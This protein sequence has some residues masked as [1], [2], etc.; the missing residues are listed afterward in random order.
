MKSWN[1]GWINGIMEKWNNGIKYLCTDGLNILDL[2][3][4]AKKVEKDCRLNRKPIFLHM[5]IPMVFQY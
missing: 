2:I 1:N 3:N 4:K 5:K